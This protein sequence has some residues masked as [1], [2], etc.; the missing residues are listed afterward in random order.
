MAKP[1]FAP[2]R[3]LLV[4]A[5]PDDESLFTGHVIA[6]AI[7]SGGA[8]QRGTVRGELAR[9]VMQFKSFPIAMVSRHWM[10]MLEAPK[11]TDGSAPAMAN[12]LLYGGAIMVTS[13]AVIG[14]LS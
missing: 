5:H 7:A 14:A 3:L 1:T 10:R 11:V 2:K 4:H 6:K 8:T 13:M 12:R 9:S